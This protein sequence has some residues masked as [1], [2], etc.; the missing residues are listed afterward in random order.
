MIKT[1]MIRDEM[2]SIVDSMLA[3]FFDELRNS[4]KTDLRG[5]LQ[6]YFLPVFRA[7][8]QVGRD[9]EIEEN[10]RLLFEENSSMELLLLYPEVAK[11]AP[12]EIESFKAWFR[13]FELS[14]KRE[15]TWYVKD[16]EGIFKYLIHV[17][18][19]GNIASWFFNEI[20]LMII[21]GGNPRNF[22]YKLLL[23]IT[24]SFTIP[25]QLQ[26]T[27]KEI[28]ETNL[29]LRYERESWTIDT[30]SYMLHNDRIHID[31]LVLS[32]FPGIYSP[33]VFNVTGFEED[34][35]KAVIKSGNTMLLLP[36]FD[37]VHLSRENH[38]HLYRSL[39]RILMKINLESRVYSEIW[40]HNQ[41][42]IEDHLYWTLKFYR[43]NRDLSY[44][45]LIDLF[46][47]LF[48]DSEIPPVITRVL[49]E[50]NANEYGFHE[51]DLALVLSYY[52]KREIPPHLK[53]RVTASLE[54]F[55][56]MPFTL[57]IMTL[58]YL[59]QREG[60]PQNI[61]DEILKM[62]YT[63]TDG[64]LNELLYAIEDMYKG[65]KLP[66]QIIES[67]MNLP[68]TG[69]TGTIK[70]SIFSGTVSLVNDRA[71]NKWVADTMMQSIREYFYESFQFIRLRDI[72][73]FLSFLI[74]TD[75][76][77]AVDQLKQIINDAIFA[78]D[79]GSMVELNPRLLFIVHILHDNTIA[80][81]PESLRAG[82]ISS[83]DN[84]NLE[85]MYPE[86]KQFV[87]A[88]SL[89]NAF[90]RKLLKSPD[91]MIRYLVIHLKLLDKIDRGFFRKIAPLS[92]HSDILIIQKE[93]GYITKPCPSGSREV[94]T[95]LFGKCMLLYRSELAQ[96]N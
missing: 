4:V 70:A 16:L 43:D 29:R 6:P 24:D 44:K 94:T 50:S 53:E 34:F 33:F 65:K 95:D 36:Y 57:K 18:N 22:A 87:E 61:L 3:E 51:C 17:L 72:K 42:A 73:S 79:A 52:K 77:D 76:H 64:R 85:S 28:F 81:F 11:A 32:F 35:E 7:L 19:N 49:L 30:F 58:D 41:L 54:N 82:I 88:M 90:Y 84:Q 8:Q 59:R 9:K 86:S 31:L 78:I 25:E 96:I 2:L 71:F 15:G 1:K 69:V 55:P 27:V 91:E 37:E 5:E 63:V 46:E 13:A 56:K 62:I 21:L 14:I 68:D 12:P 45:L 80:A 67:I 60:L 47:Y 74:R 83:I 75:N 23:A 66:D 92:P 39:L 48:G 93:N 20:N 10:F 40:Q 26:E 38:E 89:Q